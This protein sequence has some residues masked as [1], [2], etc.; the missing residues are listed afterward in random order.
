MN[1]EQLKEFH[2]NLELE[3]KAHQLILRLCKAKNIRLELKQQ[4]KTGHCEIPEI[5]AFEKAIPLT[6]N[7]LVL[8]DENPNLHI[9]YEIG[10]DNNVYAT[11]FS[12]G[13][14]WVVYEIDP[15]DDSKY[16][17]I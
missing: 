7:D 5:W 17:N 12:R 16:F 10:A 2:H 4:G 13:A 14:G 15:Q 8:I 1:A 6:E 11:E 3:E 9:K